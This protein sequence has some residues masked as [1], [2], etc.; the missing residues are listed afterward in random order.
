MVVRAAPTT[1]N[2]IELQ[3]FLRSPVLLLL[4]TEHP[5]HQHIEQ[6]VHDSCVQERIGNQL[7]YP[8]VKDIRRP[9]PA[10]GDQIIEKRW[11]KCARQHLQEVNPDAGNDDLSSPRE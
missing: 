4:R 10:E 2:K 1:Q 5:Q 3:E 8:A 9:Q 11:S 7:P 6:D